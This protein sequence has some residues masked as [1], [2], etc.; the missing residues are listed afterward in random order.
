M[1][2][3]ILI[4]LLALLTATVM[5]QKK[6]PPAFILGG[7]STGASAQS[8]SD[9]IVA[10]AVDISGVVTNYLIYQ[11][12][13]KVFVSSPN[14]LVGT[15]NFTLAVKATNAQLNALMLYRSASATAVATVDTNGFVHS[16]LSKELS[17]DST[18]VLLNNGNKIKYVIFKTDWA[19]TID[20]VNYVCIGGTTPSVTPDI[21]YGL[22]VSLKGDSII[23]NPGAVTNQTTGVTVKS[24]DTAA[25]P[26]NRYIT[27]QF[28]AVAGTTKPVTFFAKVYY[29]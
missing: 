16:C 28:D 7:G 8:I 5:A 3:T 10:H 22:D 1:K 11:S 27:L 20:S 17:L 13:P 24:F 12:A 4:L 2:R 14:L 15:N 23:T 29:H 26:I 18:L 19:I 9:S 6:Q 21:H 25:I